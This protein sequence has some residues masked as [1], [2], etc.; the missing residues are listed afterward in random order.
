[1]KWWLKCPNSNKTPV[2]WKIP[3]YTYADSR[4]ST[5]L[6]VCY[7]KKVGSKKKC[8][9]WKHLYKEIEII[10]QTSALSKVKELVDKHGQS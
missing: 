6:V 7:K 10:K 8:T 1:M 5:A 9:K 4:N 3:G 2:L